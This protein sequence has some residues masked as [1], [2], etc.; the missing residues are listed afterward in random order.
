MRKSYVFLGVGVAV[1]VAAGVVAVGATTGGSETSAG[2]SGSLPAGHPSVAATGPATTDAAADPATDPEVKRS[3]KQ[4]ENASAA[5]PRDART[6]LKLGDAYFLAQ[7]YD[8]AAK[9]FQSV[10]ELQPGNTQAT[11]RLAMV[12]HADGDT[13]RALRGHPSV[14]ADEPGRPGGSLLHGDRLLLAGARGGR[15]RR[16]GQGGRH[17]PRVGHRPPLAELRGPHRR[18]AD[19]GARTGDGE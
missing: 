1:L 9:A 10:L 5:D 19:V 7:R 14:L 12:W 2:T 3:I 11:I 13:Q 18:R 4:L 15:A 8:Q 17:R 16:V 6:L